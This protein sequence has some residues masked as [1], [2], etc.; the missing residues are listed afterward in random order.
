MLLGEATTAPRRTHPLVWDYRFSMPGKCYHQSPMMSIVHSDVPNHPHVQWKLLMS[1]N[2]TRV[3][4]Y[5][6]TADV[7]EFVTVDAPDVVAF[8]APLLEEWEASMP[9]HTPPDKVRLN[10][11]CVANGGGAL[12]VEVAPEGATAS[13]RRR[14]YE[15][16]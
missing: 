3:E 11:G 8:L 5:N 6:L 10:P 15:L 16:A 1:P 9:V 4:L 2:R 12:V 14:L 13:E 7:A